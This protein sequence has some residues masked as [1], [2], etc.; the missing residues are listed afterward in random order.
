VTA[1]HWIFGYGSLVWR[2]ELDFVERRPACLDGWARRLW[3]GSTD[4]ARGH[5]R[6]GRRVRRTERSKRRLRARLAA[7][8]RALGVNEQDDEHVFALERLQRGTE[9]PARRAL[10]P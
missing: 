8:Q 9:T 1:P 4:P 7:E 3:Q 5:R 10:I 2:P 6:A